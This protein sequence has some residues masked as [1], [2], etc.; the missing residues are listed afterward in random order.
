MGADFEAG[1]WTCVLEEALERADD[2]PFGVA[3]A[4]VGLPPKQQFLAAEGDERGEPLFGGAVG[5]F[6]GDNRVVPAIGSGD[7]NPGSAKV[8]SELHL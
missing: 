5:R 3:L 2:S 4:A 6:E 8:D 1:V 7:D